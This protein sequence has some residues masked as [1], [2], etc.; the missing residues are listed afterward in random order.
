MTASAGDEVG[1]GQDMTD[2]IDR[3]TSLGESTLY[4][5]RH[6]SVVQS[7][8]ATWPQMERRRAPRR[9][10]DTAD[11]RT[12]GGPIIL[13]AA[14]DLVVRPRGGDRHVRGYRHAVLA[15]DAAAAVVGATLAYLVRFGPVQHGDNARYVWGSLGLPVLWL[16]GVAV[17]RA[18][19]SRYLASS[20]EEYRRV[21]NAGLGL[22]A[23]ISVTSYA[24]KAD[25]ARGYVV[26][27]LPLCFV[28]SIA[29]RYVAR[30]F[31]RKARAE[32]RCLQNVLVVGHEWPVLDLIAELH[33]RPD[34]GLRVVGACLPGGQGSRQ[35]AEAGVPVVGDLNHVVTAVNKLQVDVLAVTTCVEFGGPELR[36]VCWA[37]EN[38]DVDVVVAPAL[39][40]VTG[41][42]LHIRPVAG[43]PLLHVEKPEFSGAR[44]VVKGLFDRLTAL[45][46]LTVLSPILVTIALAVRLTSSG[47]AFFRQTRV[48]VRGER[49]TMWK[50]R[51]M[52][53]DAEE[54]LAAVREMN[55][56]ADGLLFKIR[57]DPRVTKVGKFIRRYSLDELPQLFNV[58]KGDMSL[59]G[60]RPP[61]PSEVELY[62]DDVRRRLL[63]KPG[64][65]GLWQ[66]SGRSDLTWEE[67]VRLDLRYVENWSLVYDFSILWQTA[68]AVL[69]GSGAY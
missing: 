27:A 61:L 65:T 16:I 53:T 22:I 26:T 43:L 30:R 37:L 21:L 18:Y 15:V 69:R 24:L 50:F 54:R 58:L 4:K 68:F 44:R 12:R 57:D 14:D 59:V 13:P 36:Q 55:E 25:F 45:A 52:H 39:I 35:M 17:S 6:L 23:V 28:L 60:P 20:T 3:R 7:G 2:L 67:S 9:H 11:R 33:S 40:E 38:V 63:V 64:V 46:V 48:G 34:G 47:P 19:E 49:F 5:D 29:G 42:R 10:D 66:V 8:D 41:P 32:G 62:P 51:S 1:W 56:N 31:L